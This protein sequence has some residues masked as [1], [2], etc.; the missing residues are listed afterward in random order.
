MLLFLDLLLDEPRE[1]AARGVIFHL[2]RLFDEL[3]DEGRHLLF[4]LEGLLEYLGR[5]FPLVTRGGDR[6]Q[7]DMS[8][9]GDDI[10]VYLHRVFL[11][12]GGLLLHPVGAAGE[13]VGVEPGGH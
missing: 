12:F 2:H 4:V 9:A 1:H 8:A 10:F 5:V 7:N 13:V 11:L 6:L 3:I